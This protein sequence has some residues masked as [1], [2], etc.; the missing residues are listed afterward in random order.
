MSQNAETSIPK[1]YQT[2]A[3]IPSGYQIKVLGDLVIRPTYSKEKFVL[4][5]L[6]LT[7]LCEVPP[8]LVDA[9]LCKGF[10]IEEIEP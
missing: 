4:V 7:T 2:D 9:L 8:S 10:D 6:S 5:D 3:L 1:T